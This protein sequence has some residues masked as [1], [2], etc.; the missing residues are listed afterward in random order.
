MDPIAAFALS[1]C[2]ICALAVSGTYVLEICKRL[3]RKR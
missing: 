2:V 3:T 1:W